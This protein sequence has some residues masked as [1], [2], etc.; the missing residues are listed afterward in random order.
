MPLFKINTDHSISKIPSRNVDLER[1][2]QNLIEKNLKE[3]LDIDFVASEY[4]IQGGRIDTLGIDG[5]GSPVVIEYKKGSNSSIISQG[6]FYFAWLLDHKEAFEKLI[7]GKGIE[8]NV[9]WESPRLICIA[10]DFNFY[11]YSAIKMLSIKVELLK[12]RFY[13]DDLIYVT[14]DRPIEVEE[15]MKGKTLVPHKTPS[16]SLTVT[17][18]D[19]FLESISVEKRKLF[20]SIREQI[21]ALSSDVQEK[22]NKSGISFR[23][24]ILFCDT[25]PLNFK[26]IVVCF[27]KKLLTDEVIT[28]YELEVGKRWVTL[29]ITSEEG[30]KH[31]IEIAE[32][33]YQATL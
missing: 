5:N 11:D 29:R 26:E 33:T 4:V 28:K 9:N 13:G 30:V 31:C 10:E 1:D 12:Y 7:Q 16:S 2:V 18:V 24:S 20:Q 25:Y 3:S 22:V 17:D 19:S 8:I 6:G 21:L 27:P 14:A 23:T 15:R 32:Q